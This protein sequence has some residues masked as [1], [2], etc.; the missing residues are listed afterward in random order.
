M[1]DFSLLIRT[2]GARE[3][4]H[5]IFPVQK[6]RL[7]PSQILYAAKIR[8]GRKGEIKTFPDKVKVRVFIASRYAFLK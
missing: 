5:D 3:V 2:L 6:E 4:W 8:S 7:C 1:I